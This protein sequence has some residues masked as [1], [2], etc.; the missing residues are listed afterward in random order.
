[1][2]NTRWSA[3]GYRIPEDKPSVREATLLSE[4][5]RLKAEVLHLE[6]ENTSLSQINASFKSTLMELRIRLHAAGR[7]PEE[8]YEM[9]L[10]DSTLTELRSGAEDNNGV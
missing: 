1:M 8:C 10:I 5:E 3:A 9:G 2:S 6:L 7:R 4:I